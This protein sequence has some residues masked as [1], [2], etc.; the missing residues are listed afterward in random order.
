MYNIPLNQG[1]KKTLFPETQPSK[2]VG[3]FWYVAGEE[4]EGISCSVGLKAETQ[5]AALLLS[6]PMAAL[7]NC[8][9]QGALNFFPLNAL[10]CCSFTVLLDI[11]LCC[12]CVPV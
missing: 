7:E 4:R 10:L 11:S 1:H 6:S 3:T 9:K 8:S 5:E 2:N 12:T